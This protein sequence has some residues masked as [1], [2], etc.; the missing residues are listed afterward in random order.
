MSSGIITINNGAGAAIALVGGLIVVDAGACVMVKG[1]AMVDIEAGAALRAKAGARD[2]PRRRRRHQRQGRHH[3]AERV[4][5]DMRD[6]HQMN[7]QG[8]RQPPPQG[9]PAL[10]VWLATLVGRAGVALP[11][12]LAAIVERIA[13][14]LDRR[15]PDAPIVRAAPSSPGARGLSARELLAADHAARG[16]IMM[17]VVVPLLMATPGVVAGLVEFIESGG[18]HWGAVVLSAVFATFGVAYFAWSLYRTAERLRELRRGPSAP[19]SAQPHPYAYALPQPLPPLPGPAPRR[20]RAA[21]LGAREPQAHPRLAPLVD[22]FAGGSD[23]GPILRAP[24]APGWVPL[25]LDTRKALV[26][27]GKSTASLFLA[28]FAT[29]FTGFNAVTCLVGLDTRRGH[30]FALLGPTPASVVAG[31]VL[32]LFTV[33]IVV[34][35]ARSVPARIRVLRAVLARSVVVPGSIRAATRTSALGAAGAAPT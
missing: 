9:A 8:P 6:P 33:G 30:E 16:W 13:D 21:D 20:A 22:R 26:F 25:R 14:R 2:G 31:V 24:A 10:V 27:D 17:G 32:S 28:L 11:L 5:R 3:Q 34:A 15:A 18:R 23:A 7:V 1:G 19:L 35:G 4:R 29:I 12:R